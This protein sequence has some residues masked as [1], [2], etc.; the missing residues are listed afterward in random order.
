MP[1]FRLALYVPVL[2]LL[3]SNLFM[4]TA[5]YWHLRYKEVPLWQ[6]VLISWGLALIE[7]CLAVPANRWGAALYA[8]AQ[9]KTMQEVITLVV[10]A[11]FSSLYL[12]QPLAWNHAVGFAFIALGAFFVFLPLV[13]LRANIFRDAGRATRVVIH[14]RPHRRAGKERH[15]SAD[16]DHRQSEKSGTCNTATRLMH[17]QHTSFGDLHGDRDRRNCDRDDQCERGDELR[18]NGG[19]DAMKTGDAA[20]MSKAGNLVVGVE[21]GCAPLQGANVHGR[22]GSSATRCVF[23]RPYKTV[24]GGRKCTERRKQNLNRGAPLGGRR[25]A[26]HPPR[27]SRLPY[28]YGFCAIPR[29]AR[30]LS[31]TTI[32]F[33]RA[34]GHRLL[35]T[36]GTRAR[37]AWRFPIQPSFQPCRSFSATITSISISV[38]PFAPINGQSMR[39]TP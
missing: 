1:S 34:V 7:Y 37:S 23:Q 33:L 26:R 8:P 17:R 18:E 30:L 11:G 9:L 27:R 24:R 3:S 38:S 19:P 35:W 31:P 4:T 14:Q 15:Q 25:T 13:V 10:F 6:V 22:I 36:R 16:R 29:R 32:T 5:W 12:N 21:H 39:A 20:W 28:L 2:L